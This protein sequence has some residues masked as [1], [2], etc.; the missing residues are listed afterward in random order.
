LNW[1]AAMMLFVILFTSAVTTVAI[2]F[3]ELNL[4]GFSAPER[5]I[6]DRGLKPLGDS[7][8]GPGAPY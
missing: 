2:S 4:K 7:V 6:L 3:I 1:K 8:G 5:A